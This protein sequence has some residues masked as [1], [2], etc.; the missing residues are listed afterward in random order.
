MSCTSHQINGL[1]HQQASNHLLMVLLGLN[2]LPIADG[3]RL[4]T[5]IPWAMGFVTRTWTQGKFASWL[6]KKCTMHT[7]N[8]WGNHILWL[9][10]TCLSFG[11]QLE[12]AHLTRNSKLFP[13]NFAISFSSTSTLTQLAVIWMNIAIFI[14]FTYSTTGLRCTHTSSKCVRLALGVPSL[15]IWGDIVGAD[16]PFSYWGTLLM[17]FIDAYSTEKYSGFKGNKTYLILACSMT[18]FSAMEPIQHANSTNC[19]S[20]IMK[21]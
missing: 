12:A 19:V 3:S 9:R 20:G 10:T 1:P 11:S 2:F 14:V 5:V 13:R 16:L 21:I 8:H 17:R 15:T 18:G 4:T 7:T 6:W